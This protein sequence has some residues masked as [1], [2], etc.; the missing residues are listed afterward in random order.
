MSAFSGPQ[1]A[2]ARRARRAQKHAQAL[3]RNRVYVR[4]YAC[5]HKHSEAQATACWDR[6]MK[7]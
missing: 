1:G 5:G 4:V 3:E 2:G 6:S 7:S